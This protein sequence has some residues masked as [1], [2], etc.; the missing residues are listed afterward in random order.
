MSTLAPRKAA[1]RVQAPRPRAA[2]GRP[3]AAMLAAV[4]DPPQGARMT[5]DQYHRTATEFHAELVDGRLDYLEMPYGLHGDL[6]AFLYDALR[7]HRRTR[8]PRAKLRFP[9]MPVLIPGAPSGRNSRD[10]DLVLLL[11]RDDPRRTPNFWRGADL[12]VEVVSPD[13][14]DRDY[15]AK[16]AD[17]AAAGVTEYWV[18]DP[19]PRTAADPRGRAVRVLTLDGGAYRERTFGEGEAATSE[20][21]PGFAVDVTA[22]F[23]AE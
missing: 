22:C 23:A 3:T 16:R 19:R 6:S 9:K 10:P 14:P 21:L 12:C 20:L 11:D 13:D 15:V 17:Y 8:F 4:G 2:G 18:V 1:R 7:D 5:L